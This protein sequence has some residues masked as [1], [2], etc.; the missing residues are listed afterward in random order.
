MTTLPHPKVIVGSEQEVNYLI[1]DPAR[2]AISSSMPDTMEDPSRNAISSSLD[3][4]KGHP[5]ETAHPP[6][7]IMSIK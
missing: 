5:V 4:Q 1:D 7:L 2:N 6:E 3:F